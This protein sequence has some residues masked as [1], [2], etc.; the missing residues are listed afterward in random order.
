MD[1][2]S[3]LLNAVR[4]TGGVFLSAH[5][6]APWC[7]NVAMSA[8][9]CAPY[10]I[11]PTH[12]IAFHVVTEGKLLVALEGEPMLEVGAGEIVLFPQNDPHWLAD[13]EGLEPVSARH[14]IQKSTDG[15]PHQIRYGGDGASTRVVCG[16]LASDLD[17]NPLL[18]TLPKLLKIDIRRGA[19]REWIEA[20]VRFAAGELAAGRLASSGVMTRLSES[21]LTEAVRQYSAELGEADVGW[22]KGVRDP[23]IGRA[24]A[25]MHQKLAEPWSTDV[26]AAKVAL[27]RSA[28]VERFSSL[29]GMPPIRYLTVWRLQT[30]KLYLRESKTIAQV[31]H[32]V[33]YESVEAFSRAFK[34]EYG[35][36]PAQWRDQQMA[37]AQSPASPAPT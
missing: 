33:G 13:K 18:A 19:S 6:T 22:L 2:L 32:A 14:L 10:Q 8:R 20:S 7:V 25:L 15:G 36:S 29:I 28:F 31:A 37:G 11:K 12:I 5:F 23:Q 21:L 3:D 34:R 4:L 16:F 1:P 30:A 26:L 9:D 24:L 27:S 35:V 17:Y